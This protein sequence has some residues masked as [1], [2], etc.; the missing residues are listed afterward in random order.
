M[1]KSSTAL[2]QGR[3]PALLCWVM[4][5]CIQPLDAWILTPI[6]HHCCQTPTTSTGRNLKKTILF[7]KKDS[8]GGPFSFLFNPYESK[9]PSELYDE[10]Y[11]AEAKTAAAQERGVRVAT[12]AAIAFAGIVLA[13]F[14]A[15]VTE[16]RH[17]PLPEGAP[18]DLDPL[19]IAGFTWVNSNFLFQFLLTNKLGGGLCLLLG[20]GSGLMAEAELDTKR[21]NAEKIFEEMERRR[22]RK[23]KKETPRTTGKKKRR[24]GKEKKRMDALAEVVEVKDSSKE[25]VEASEAT[26]QNVQE[27]QSQPQQQDQKGD[28][29]F[30]KLKSFYDKADNMAASQALLLN[31]KLEDTGVIEKITD[32]TGLKVIGKEEAAK[33]KAQKQQQEQDKESSP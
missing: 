29:V 21:I 8:G 14:N 17:T 25:K 6:H 18:S 19:A 24:S 23:V 7:D 11:A 31:K 27:Q 33:L 5:V 32:E 12:Y 28:G 3:V 20:A 26:T 22:E 10:I 1:K 16:L 9:I 30:G 4:L 13:F 2:R 15:F